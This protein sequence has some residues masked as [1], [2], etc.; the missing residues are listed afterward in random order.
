MLLPALLLLDHPCSSPDLVT[1]RPA[2]PTTRATCQAATHPCSSPLHGRCRRP[3][4]LFGH[5]ATAARPCSP[6]TRLLPRPP[7]WRSPEL[8]P[9]P[10]PPPPGCPCSYLAQLLPRR[11][12]PSLHR[13]CSCPASQ[14][15]LLR[16]ARKVSSTC[17]FYFGVVMC[18][19]LGICLLCGSNLLQ[20]GEMQ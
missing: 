7:G 15:V 3:A 20:Q 17:D 8:L 6:S 2:Y 1:A 11:V 10:T 4:H 19:A 5:S 18:S 16:A 14:V 13:P 9:D 12:K